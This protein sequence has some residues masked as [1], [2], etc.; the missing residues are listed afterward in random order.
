MNDTLRRMI[1]FAIFVIVVLGIPTMFIYIQSET[2]CQRLCNSSYMWK[3]N[4][5]LIRQEYKCE[6]GNALVYQ[7]WGSCSDEDG[8]TEQC[9]KWREECVER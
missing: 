1:F 7:S 2:T 6:T 9:T 3:N 5:H 8:W 4:N